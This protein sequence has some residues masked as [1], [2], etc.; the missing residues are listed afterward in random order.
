MHCPNCSALSRDGA[1]FCSRCGT[2]LP[3]AAEQSAR[4][5]PQFC[6][7]CGLPLPSSGDHFCE[8]SES[9]RA[10][11]PA[12]LESERKEVTVVF[13]DISESTKLISGLDP[14][15]AWA[16]LDPILRVMNDAVTA[17]GG[18]VVQIRGDGIMALIGA[19][20]AQ[21]GHAARG[22]CAAVRMRQLVDRLFDSERS[23]S[24]RRIRIHIGIATG[25]ALVGTIGSDLNF[26]YNAVGEVLHIAARLQSLAQPGQ[27][28]CTQESI[29]QTA[30]LI[31]GRSMG[32]TE[33]RGV[34]EPVKVVEVVGPTPTRLRFHA[35][36]ARGLTPF[37]GRQ[38]EF[39]ILRE[40]LACAANGAG[41]LVELVGDAGIGK[42]RLVWEF[43]RD[44]E[45]Q[46]WQVL[47]AG[48]IFYAGRTIYYPITRLLRQC[49]GIGDL[50]D[51]ET[52]RRKVSDRLRA[53]APDLDD[54]RS[55]I[56]FLLDMDPED[57]AWAAMDPPKRRAAVSEAFV[58]LAIKLGEEAPT[59]L[60]VED[61]NWIDNATHALLDALV[62][63]MATARVLLLVDYRKGHDPDWSHANA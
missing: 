2:A 10:A 38:R 53:F 46:G 32:E 61:L 5:S 60:V 33:L 24:E 50:D 18:T 59:V 35:S 3:R 14:E 9:S 11:E 47:E 30:G 42:S 58:R 37:L 8:A 39:Q 7:L 55:A 27:T 20:L 19:P 17:Y 28:L 57:P 6:D 25:E 26:S 63:Q 31:T 43:T 21:E 34:R 23:A 40:C 51:G 41:Q 45:I 1:R 4:T 29:S 56:M 16:L 49:F 22:C 48:G 12:L 44:S 54:A 52:S 62:G 15:A 36:V 13:A